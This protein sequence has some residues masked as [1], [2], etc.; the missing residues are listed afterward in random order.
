MM[1]TVLFLHEL[2]RVIGTRYAEFESAY[3]DDWAPRLAGS[4]AGRLLWYLDHAHGS[5]PAYNVVTLTAV[6]DATMW[7]ELAHSAQS[8]DLLEWAHHVDT[9]RYEV[10]AKLLRPLSWSPLQSVDFEA[11]P[12]V[13]AA[14]APAVY[15]EDTVWPRPGRLGEYIDAA[16]D[17]YRTQMAKRGLLS[18]SAAFQPVLGSHVRNEVILLQ[19][20]LDHDK[21]LTLLSTD[22]AAEH[23]RPGSWMEEAVQWRDRWRSRLLRTA[24]WSPLQ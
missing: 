6:R 14:P 23:R 7:E 5:G 13:S 3:R 9:L 2:H 1:A 16:G 11:I 17:L 20:V 4:G 10:T 8:G 19:R 24:L 18:L 12:L 21:L 22:T 15:M